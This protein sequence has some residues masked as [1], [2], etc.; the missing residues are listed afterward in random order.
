MAGVYMPDGSLRVTLAAGSTTTISTVGSRG[1]YAPDGSYKVTIVGAG[2]GSNM[3]L[4]GNGDSVNVRDASPTTTAATANVT[5]DVLNYVLLSNSIK[6]VRNNT[7]YTCPAPTGTYA[8]QV[9]FTI[10]NGQITG[11]VFS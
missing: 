8:S 2:A 7:A 4:I 1:V 5:N 6:L 11:I 10:A 9:T 3:V